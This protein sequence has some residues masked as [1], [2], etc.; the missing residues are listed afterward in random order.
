M[1]ATPSRTVA[2]AWIELRSDDPA[3]V[4]AFAV[5]RARLAAGRSLG[6]LRR[7][8]LIEVTG[9]LPAPREVDALLHRSI[10]FYNPH[11]ERCTLR[12]ATADA[13]PTG[14]GEVLVCVTDRGGERR[15]GA[16]RWWRHQT[17][18]QADVR[19]SVVW[20]LRF[21]GAAD[22]L[23]AARELALL[24]DRHQGLLCNPH[25]QTMDVTAGEIPLPWIRS[26]AR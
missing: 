14:A 18:E 9:A 25:A 20:A 22:P 5:A 2:Q 3:A 24:V 6:G 12:F 23:A 13:A 16:E 7:L 19:E 15:P 8:R 10:Q 17:G 11:K 21:E 1:N 4:S 26:D